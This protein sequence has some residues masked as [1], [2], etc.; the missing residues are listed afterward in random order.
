MQK[1]NITIVDDI[2]IEAA[3]HIDATKK[4]V[5][6]HPVRISAVAIAIATLFHISG[7]SHLEKQ[8]AR[9]TQNT[10]VSQVFAQHMERENETARHPVRFD[11]GLRLPSTVGQ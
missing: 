1:T 6:S 7:L 9:H 11:E 4:Y 3:Q 5:R 8:V 10:T 2:Q